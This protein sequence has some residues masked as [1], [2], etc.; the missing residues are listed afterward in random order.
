PARLLAG[1][2]VVVGYDSRFLSPEFAREAAALLAARGF[3]VLFSK[4]FVPTPVVSFQ[5][6]YQKALG[7]VNF[8]ASHNPAEYNGIKFNGPEG[9]PATPEMTKAIERVANAI[10]TDPIAPVLTSTQEKQIVSFDARPA[11]L[12]A[13]RKV[14]DVSALKKA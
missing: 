10:E 8:T 1:S 2:P 13:L 3:P 12:T 9:A 6:R 5:I 14:V 4:D 11:Y 7:G